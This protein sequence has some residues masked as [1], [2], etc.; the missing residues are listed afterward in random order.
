MSATKQHF[1]EKIEAGSREKITYLQF[2]DMEYFA[3]DHSIKKACI[4]SLEPSNLSVKI[5]DAP[6]DYIDY[7]MNISTGEE[8]T[9]EL[10]FAKYTEIILE[11]IAERAK[12]KL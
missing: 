1:H 12:L 5:F 4:V 7:V 2:P 8:I 9:K 10:F 3:I 6:D 11:L